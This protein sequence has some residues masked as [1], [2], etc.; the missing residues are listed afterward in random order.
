MHIDSA[1]LTTT[2][3]AMIGNIERWMVP[4]EN[5]YGYTELAKIDHHSHLPM[6]SRFAP[7]SLHRR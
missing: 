4:Y 3:K 1:A 6:R 7:E 5:V 2:T